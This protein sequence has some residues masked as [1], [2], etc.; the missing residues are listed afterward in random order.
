MAHPIVPYEEWLT[1][2]EGLLAKERAMTHQLDE[3]RAERRRLPLLL[4]LPLRLLLYE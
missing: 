1:A 3:L 4:R 2:R